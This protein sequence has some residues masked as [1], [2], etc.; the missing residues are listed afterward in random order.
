MKK[1]IVLICCALVAFGSTNVFAGEKESAKKILKMEVSHKLTREE[2]STLE[3]RVK[4]IRDMKT[5]NLTTK[6]KEELR[7]ELMEIKD[8]LSAEPFTGI[9]LSAGAIIIILLILLI[10]T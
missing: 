9:Y 5:D 1:I 3:N 4:E 10:I 8:R 6:E 2:R 7:N